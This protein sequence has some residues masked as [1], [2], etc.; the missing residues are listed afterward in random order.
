MTAMLRTLFLASL[1]FL[2][3]APVAAGES[4]PPP[5]QQEEFLPVDQL[6]P[7]EQMPAA[8]LLIGAYSFVVVTLFVYLVSVSRRLAIV[9]REVERLEGDLKR[10]RA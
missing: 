10:G 1:L 3:A 4:Q 6:P 2:G 5:E 9:Q 7:G 8:P